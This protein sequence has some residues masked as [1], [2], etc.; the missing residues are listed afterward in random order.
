MEKVFNNEIK[1]ELLEESEIAK[2]VKKCLTVLFATPAGSLAMDRDFGL[3]MDF[4]D[5]PT[6]QAKAEIMQEIMIKVSRYEPRAKIELI[7]FSGNEA[8]GELIPKIEVSIN[9]E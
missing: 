2:D 1:I 7:S 6:E 3:N 4:L 5:L 8:N 9:Y